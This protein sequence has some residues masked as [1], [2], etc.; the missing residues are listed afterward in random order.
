MDITFGKVFIYLATFISLYVTTLWLIVF[1]KNKNDIYKSKIKKNY[2]FVSVIVPCFNEEKTIVKTVYSLVN[3]DYPKDKLEIIII[4]DGSTDKT[5]QKAEKLLKHKQVKLFSKKNGGKWTAL[6]YGVK[7]AD[8]K[9]EFIGCLDADSFVTPKALKI[10]MAYF[11]D[12]KIMAV[13]PSLKV[14][15]PKNIIQSVQKIEYIFNIILRKILAWLN[16][17]TVTPGPF[18]IYRKKVFEELGLFVHGHNTEDM[19]MAFRLQSKNY[20]ITN[21]PDASVY[22]ITPAS[23]KKLQRQRERWYKGFIKNAWDYRYIFTN[24]NYKDLGLFVLPIVPLTLLIYIIMIFYALFLFIQNTINKFVLW[25]AVNFDLSQITFNFNWFFI[26]TSTVI[27]VGFFVLIFVI[28][29]FLLGKKIS[30]E[31]LEIKKDLKDLLLFAF[32]YSPLFL[33]WWLGTVR[34][35]FS[36]KGN[37]W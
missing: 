10:I 7:K 9:A 14:Y 2:P 16:S 19:E 34:M 36:K 26:N 15:Q 29:L 37:R 27:L 12:K 13:T 22:T 24:K 8:A 32:L 21:A 23:F 33:F 4:D 20:R 18:S 6:N 3:L 5:Y 28:S 35:T 17:I 11:T 30:N 31:N 1:W 25:Q